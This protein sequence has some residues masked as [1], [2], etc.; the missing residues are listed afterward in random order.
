MGKRLNMAPSDFGDDGFLSHPD[1]ADVPFVGLTIT[2][3]EGRGHYISG[4]DYVDHLFSAAL[5]CP[6]GDQIDPH[7]IG[8][9]TAKRRLIVI[10]A[11]C[12]GMF[13]WFKGERDD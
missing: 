1:A 9:H 4:F 2:D 5:I 6:C 8:L 11:K 7:A 12:C 13:R 3:S 10:P